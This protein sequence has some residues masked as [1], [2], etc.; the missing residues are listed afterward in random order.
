MGGKCSQARLQSLGASNNWGTRNGTRRP[1]MRWTD[2]MKKKAG[3][4]WT[5]TARN[6]DDWMKYIALKYFENF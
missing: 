5:G 4:L 3:N 6:R 1:A 2:G